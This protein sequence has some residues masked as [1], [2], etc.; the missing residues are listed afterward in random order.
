[1]TETPWYEAFVKG[2]RLWLKACP[3]CGKTTRGQMPKAIPAKRRLK[4]TGKKGRKMDPEG[5][6]EI[7]AKLPRMRIPMPAWVNI[8][9]P[10]SLFLREKNG[11][12][13]QGYQV[14]RVVD[15]KAG[16]ILHNHVSP[17]GG[18]SRELLPVLL[19]TKRVMG[20]SQLLRALADLA[21][22][23]PT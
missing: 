19:A 5:G 3:K 20:V 6:R 13:L 9:D 17:T 2:F 7:H 8:T 23:S 10:A 4:R 14:I 12:F 1:V 18:E 22:R 11:G 21:M 15:S 16:M